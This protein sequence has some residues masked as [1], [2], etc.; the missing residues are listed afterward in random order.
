[1][2]KQQRE[3]MLLQAAFDGNLRLLRKMARGLD[4]TGQQ[5]EAVVLAAVADARSGSRALHLAA[6]EGRMDVLRYLV[7]DIRLDVNQTNDKD[8]TPLFLSAFFGRTAAT[9]YL[10][11]HGADP[12]I[13]GKSGSPLH[14]AVGKGHCE[15]VELL[16]SRGIGIVFH[17][18][19]GTPLHTA[20][21]RGQVSTMKI[22]LDHHADP[23]KVFNL[24]DTPLILAISS[25]S[26]ECVKLLIQAGADVNFRDSNGDT[27]VMV[28]AKYGFS[29][30]MKCLLDAGANPNIPDEFGAFPIEVAALQGHREIVEILFPLTLPISMLPD[31]SIDGIISHVKNFGLK[32]DKDLCVK[33]LAQL[34]LRGKEAFRRKEYLLAGQLYTSAI[35]L[36][37]NPDDYATLLANRS[38]CWL[39]LENGERALV[40]GNMCRMLQPHWPKAC[41]RQGAAFMLLKEY[42]NACKAFLD[43]LKIDP[44]NV[45]MENALRAAVEAMRNDLC[46]K[47]NQ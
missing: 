14:V 2:A 8:E 44:T 10:I 42:E 24:D 36:G 7:E 4:M 39:R 25:K 16:L 35:E 31:W 13:V 11:D 18:L 17:P 33:K 15:I 9:R 26:L 21:T 27:Y 3:R 29:G 32:R 30:V 34:K 1:M 23:N 6:T 28:A 37:S 19:H 12:M 38:L 43:G 46:T 40:D 20:A 5:G 45:E 22:L 41:Y 47:K